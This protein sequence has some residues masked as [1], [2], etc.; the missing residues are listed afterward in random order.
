MVKNIQ[1]PRQKF[2]EQNFRLPSFGPGHSGGL[3]HFLPVLQMSEAGRGMKGLR[4]GPQEGI[5][6]EAEESRPAR[7]GWWA[8]T[9]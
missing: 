6:G 1:A 7:E 4:V 5:G 8:G 2:A 3:S 9:G